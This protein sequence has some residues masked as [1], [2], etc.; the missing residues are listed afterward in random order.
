MRENVTFNLP[1]DEIRVEVEP[2]LNPG[3]V[4]LM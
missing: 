4:K 1:K 2:G 3:Q